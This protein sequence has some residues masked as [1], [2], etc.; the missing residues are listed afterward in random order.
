MTKRQ[1]DLYAFIKRYWAEHGRSPSYDDIMADMRLASKSGVHRLVVGL[2]RQGLLRRVP[3]YARTL[4]IAREPN[5][6]APMHPGDI[7][8]AA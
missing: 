2:H 4:E 5:R 7:G 8:L 3:G 6:M 1:Q